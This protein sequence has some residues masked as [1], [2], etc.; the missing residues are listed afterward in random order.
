MLQLLTF[1][2]IVFHRLSQGILIKHFTH[3][4]LMKC[5][6]ST[7]NPTVETA[8]MHPVYIAVIK[9]Y[10]TTYKL[11]LYT[12]RIFSAILREIFIQIC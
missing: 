12:N 2:S 8:L 9:E 6:S 7:V 5:L 4:H 3:N 11:F 1:S 10:L